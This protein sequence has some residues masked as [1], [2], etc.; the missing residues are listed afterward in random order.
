MFL[1]APSKPRE[2]V[3]IVTSPVSVRV[4]WLQPSS[5]NGINITYS[6]H[7]LSENK[8][9]SPIEGQLKLSEDVEDQAVPFRYFID[10]TSLTA[11]T[12]YAFMV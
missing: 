3:A 12:T 10:I 7:W 2:V 9:G 1:S 4:Q 11:N 6:V 5:L 8:F